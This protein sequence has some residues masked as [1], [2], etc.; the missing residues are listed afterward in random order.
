MSSGTSSSS[1]YSASIPIMNGNG[2]SNE[3]FIESGIIGTNT[4][5]HTNGKMNEHN[6]D[7]NEESNDQY[8][9]MNRIFYSRSTLMKSST[10]TS[11]YK[12]QNIKSISHFST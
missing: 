8:F 2:A 9:E 3:F 10:I 7:V 11:V 5:I 4:C 1:K 12:A 6:A